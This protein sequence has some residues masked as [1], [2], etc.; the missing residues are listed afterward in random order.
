MKIY[1]NFFERFAW[2]EHHD[3]HSA[4]RVLARDFVSIFVEIAKRTYQIREFLK[5]QNVLVPLGAQ[6]DFTLNTFYC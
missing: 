5:F 2:R 1:F 3:A 6:F 4:A